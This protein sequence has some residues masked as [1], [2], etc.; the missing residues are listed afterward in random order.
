MIDNETRENIV[1]APFIWHGGKSRQMGKILPHLPQRKGYCEPFGGSAAILLARKPSP[2]EVYNDRHGGVTCF[3]RVIRNASTLQAFMDRVELFVHSREEFNFCRDTW[4][5]TQD[6]VERAA[7][8]YY[9][10]IYSFGGHGRNFGRSVS[11]DG[12]IF[13]GKLRNKIDRFSE[14]HARFRNVQVENLDWEQCMLDYD[15]PEMV[16]Y[17]DPPYLDT[18]DAYSGFNFNELTHL[19]FLRHVFNSKGF[20]AVTGYKS[21]LYEAFPWS[22]VIEWDQTVYAESPT[23]DS[24]ANKSDKAA[25]DTRVEVLYIKEA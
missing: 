5:N 18:Y 7:R 16:F 19:R 23:G 2:L 4:E 1:R 24:N 13:A 8:W 15:D 6:D 21:S 11:V 3:Y 10:Q 12:P 14:I 20:V 9:S 17:C 22:N 25:R